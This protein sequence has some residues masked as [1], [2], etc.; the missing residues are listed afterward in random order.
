MR[1]RRER[2]LRLVEADMAVRPEAEQLQVDTARR[3]DGLLVGRA[4]GVGVGVRALGHV[5]ARLVN[6][7]VVEQVLLHEVAVA[8]V[9]L[10]VEAAVLVQ[11]ERGHVGEADLAGRAVLHEA[12]VQPDGRRTRGQPQH[13]GRVGVHVGGDTVGRLAAHVLGA[14]GDDEFHGTLSSLAFLTFSGVPAETAARRHPRRRAG[15]GG[16]GT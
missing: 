3:L 5:R 10:G 16:V 2:V 6:V 14:L 15:A 1:G 12:R 11:V 7:H 9:V 13:A 4:H 8:L